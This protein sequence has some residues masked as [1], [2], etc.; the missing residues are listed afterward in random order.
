MK[1]VIKKHNA[2]VLK[3]QKLAEKGS[4]N[5]RVKNNCPLYVK[6]WDE[7]NM[8]Q[9]NVV[10]NNECKEYFGTAAGE[11]KLHYNKHTMLF[12]HIKHVNDTE[13]SK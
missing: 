8:Y 4:C 5:C 1:N 3:D 2:R 10:T 6:C 7:C 12:R 13:L 11:F 9:A